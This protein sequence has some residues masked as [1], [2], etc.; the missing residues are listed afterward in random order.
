MET[1]AATKGATCAESLKHIELDRAVSNINKVVLHARQLFSDV[2]GETGEAEA[3]E[4][5]PLSAAEP[6]PSLVDVLNNCPDKIRRQCDEV[7][8]LLSRIRKVL[9]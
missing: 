4:P 6:V 9:L 7:H 8:E 1:L 2:T 3:T 5:V